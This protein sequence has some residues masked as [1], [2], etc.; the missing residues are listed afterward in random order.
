MEKNKTYHH[1]RVGKTILQTEICAQINFLPRQYEINRSH[2][3]TSREPKCNKF[4]YFGPKIFKVSISI[5]LFSKKT[6]HIPRILYIH[7]GLFQVNRGSYEV[8]YLGEI[9]KAKLTVRD[10]AKVD[11]KGNNGMAE[12]K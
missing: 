7:R 8:E 10:S 2:I 12:I 3:F 5:G 11:L 1:Y 6:S 9:K 4:F